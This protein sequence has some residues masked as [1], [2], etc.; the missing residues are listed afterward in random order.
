MLKILEKAIRIAVNAHF[1][2]TDKA[3]APYILHPLRVMGLVSS[4]EEK[5]VA[6]LHD[7]VEKTDLSFENLIEAGIPRH[8]VLILRVLTR[9]TDKSYEGYI[10]KISENPVATAV[11]IADLKDNMDFSRFSNVT[12]KDFERLQK[13]TKSLK[14]LKSVSSTK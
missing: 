8:I 10:E 14:Y 1:G 3:G 4:T 13:Y 9:A 5:I 7:V 11:K 2:Q 6:V 12:E